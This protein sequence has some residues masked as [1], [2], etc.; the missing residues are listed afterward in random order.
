MKYTITLSENKKYLT[1]K[2]LDDFTIG[3]VKQWSLGAAERSRELNIK[4]FLFD[5]RVAH[6]ACTI[7]ENYHSA[8]RDHA[9][10]HLPRDVCSAIL[11]SEEDRS[12][13]VV[14]MAYQS[15]GFNVKIFTDEAA[16]VKWLEEGG[17]SRGGGVGRL[18][19]DRFTEI[20]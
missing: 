5:V 14:E 8:Y 11:I 3:V 2:V 15:A 13:D 4:K 10:L 20:N 7:L 9:E 12:H 16:A 1:I 17:N 19:N 18:V 6:N